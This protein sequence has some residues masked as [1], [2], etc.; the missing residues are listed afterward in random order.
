MRFRITM[1]ALAATAALALSGCSTAISGSAQAGDRLPVA[2]DSLGG[3]DGGDLAL[4]DGDGAIPDLGALLEGLTG[5][6]DGEGGDLSDLLGDIMEGMGDGEA[7]GV[8]GI[9]DLLGGSECLG[10]V[11]AFSGL[12]MLLMQPLFG[13]EIT[14]ADVDKAFSGL[15]DVPSEIAGDIAVLHEAASK[16]VGAGA[17]SASEIINSPEVSAAMDHISAYIEEACTGS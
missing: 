8:P 13:G 6:G 11:G 15:G 7:T 1:A 14:Q 17:G 10:V 4:P 12:S 3:S 16:A 9:A 5:E 2:Q